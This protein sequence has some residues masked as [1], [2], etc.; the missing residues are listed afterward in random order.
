MRRSAWIAA[1]GAFL[2]VWG[3]AA[4]TPV[5]SEDGVSYFW[6][7]QRFAAGEWRA[8]LSMVF[9][10][11]W[12]LLLA[13]LLACGVAA[14]RAAT[15]LG[16]ASLAACVWPLVRIA[17][18]LHPDA[19]LPAAVLWA[20]SPLLLRVAAEGYSEPPFLVLMA[21]GT[22]AGLRGRFVAMG[23]CSGIAFWLRPEGFA[24]AASFVL[25]QPRAAWRSLLPAAG[26]VLALASL[27]AGAGLGF[28]ALP[29]VAFHAQRDDLPDRGA[30]LANLLAMPGP[31]FEA[32][33]VAGLTALLA[34]WRRREPAAATLRWQI[35]LQLAAI[36]TFV[37]RRRFFLSCAVPVV[38]LAAAVLARAPRRVAQAVLVLAIVLGAV[39]AWRG[40]TDADRAVE[41]ELGVWLAQALPRDGALVT[42]LPRVAW[43]A[44][45][46]PPPPRHF[47]AAQLLAQAHAADVRCVVL[48]I[49]SKRGQF[50]ELAAGL[51]DAFARAELPASLRDAADARGIAVFVAR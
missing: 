7:A 43:Y 13:P 30:L 9:P 50:A 38:V 20:S 36:C 26:G 5:P 29:L 8:A 21:F 14:E 28:D 46:R 33:G 10:P 45:R 39:F 47:A 3:L 17:R 35:A 34:P 37:V 1:G 25:V 24:L 42:D 31:W 49:D 16:A 2:A 41:R 15:L 44:G 40:R 11:G 27:R 12:P 22:L 4:A 23:V 19:E 51:A 6:M 48:S 32:F 18:A